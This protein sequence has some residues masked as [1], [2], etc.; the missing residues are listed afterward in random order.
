MNSANHMI[1]YFQFGGELKLGQKV[2]HKDWIGSGY[3]KSFVTSKS[4]KTNHLGV[5]KSFQ[6]N[7]KKFRVHTLNFFCKRVNNHL[8][9]SLLPKFKIFTNN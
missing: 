3:E 9:Y 1:D 8:N 7:F 5:V 2:R 4:I 6:F